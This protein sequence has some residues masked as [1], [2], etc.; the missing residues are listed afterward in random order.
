LISLSDDEDL[1]DHQRDYWTDTVVRPKQ[2]NYWPNFVTRRRKRIPET[3]PQLRLYDAG[4]RLQRAVLNPRGVRV[5]FVM[6]KVGLGQY[7]S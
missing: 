4:F 1:D 3:T 2:V 6:V 5:G 7:P